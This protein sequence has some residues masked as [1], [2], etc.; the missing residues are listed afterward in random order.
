[1]LLLVWRAKD[2][3][4]HLADQSIAVGCRSESTQE[5]AE[6]HAARPVTSAEASRPQLP[7]SHVVTGNEVSTGLVHP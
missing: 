2:C 3:A 4:P 6:T 1:M 7:F 5:T